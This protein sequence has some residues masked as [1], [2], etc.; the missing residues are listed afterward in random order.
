MI[1]ITVIILTKDEEKNI[2]KCIDS[3]LGFSK[4]IVVMDSYST[5]KTLEIAKSLGADIYQHEFRHYGAQFQYALDNCDIKTQWV[6]RLDADEEV[7]VETKKELEYLCNKHKDTD[8]NGFVFRLQET[9]LN[10]RLRYSGLNVLEKLCIFKYGKAYMEDRYMGEHIIL[11]EGKSIKLK[12][13]SYHNDFKDI[14]FWINKLN[15]YASRE[16]KDYLYQKNRVQEIS[17]LDKPTKIRRFMKY[18]IYYKMPMRLRCWL[19][20]IY[21]YI[22]RLGFLDGRAGYYR[23]YF[24]VYWYRMLVDSKIYEA[25]IMGKTIEETGSW[26]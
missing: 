8:I 21:R 18:N 3:V 17:A 6:F 10:R 24:M 16:A 25:E 20:F 7:S 1:D 15:W 12:S 23:L 2:K 13:L 19:V 22:F 26:N 14:T 4:R 11:T 9:F 5:D